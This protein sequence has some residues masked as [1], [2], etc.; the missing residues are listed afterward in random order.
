M[1]VLWK[2]KHASLCAGVGNIIC[3]KSFLLMCDHSF[4]MVREY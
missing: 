2:I 1:T 4:I 3:E